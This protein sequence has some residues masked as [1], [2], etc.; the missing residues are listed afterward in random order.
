MGSSAEPSPPVL[1]TRRIV[2]HPVSPED[3]PELLSLFREPVV[4]RYLLDDRVV[5]AAWVAAEVAASRERFRTGSAGLWALRVKG[6][7][8]GIVGFAGFRPFFDPPELQLLYGLHPDVQGRGYA[9][10][11]AAAVLDHGFTALGLASAKAATDVPN[12]A[13]VAVLERLGMALDRVTDDGPH[14]TAFY[15]LERPAD[16]SGL[17]T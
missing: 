7:S 9:T 16:G 15:R 6:G 3:E 2:L 12:R 17:R 10:E 14:G 4:R 1:T 8:P 13:S 5:D 11:A